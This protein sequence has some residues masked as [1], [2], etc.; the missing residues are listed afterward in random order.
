MIRKIVTA[1]AVT[2][3]AAGLYVVSG[4]SAQ[5]QT[6]PPWCADKS[7]LAIIGASSETGYAT[8][9]YPAGAQTF[10]PTTYGWAT[11]FANSVKSQ[12]QT[13]T[14]NYSHNGAMASDYLP[15]GR[16][17]S[18]MAATADVAARKPSIV[19]VNLGGNEYWSQ[20]SPATFQT[21]LGTLVDNIRA[22][23]PNAV[24]VLGI[25]PELKWVQSGD[26]G[27]QPQKYS[28]AQYG[29]VVYNTAVAKG[30]A[31][32]DLRQYIPPATSTSLPS[33]S[34]W[35]TDGIHQNDAGNLG[36]YGAWW[37]WVSS[38]WSMCG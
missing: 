22:A 14:T 20:A 25:Y 38:L 19:L 24:V 12:W 35:Y 1:L 2:A 27:N 32:I 31:L 4:P 23:S 5:A 37:G 3:A 26:S 6:P 16:W 8:T 36:E 17:A 34:P 18:T 33:P 28:W 15:G 7:Q 11:R 21:T 10:Q 30:T 29:T 13:T 9:G